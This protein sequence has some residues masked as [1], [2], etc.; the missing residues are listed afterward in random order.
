MYSDNGTEQRAAG[1]TDVSGGLP[2]ALELGGDLPC[3]RC[4][5]NLK[6]LSIRAVCPECGAPVRATLL[7]VVDPLASELQ[8]LSSPRLTAW[9]VLMWGVTPV[10]ACVACWVIRS[11]EVLSRS[12]ALLDRVEAWRVVVPLMAALSGLGSL[13]LIRPHARIPMASRMQAMFGVLSYVA[14]VPVIWAEFVVERPLP[15]G[16]ALT[17]PVGMWAVWGLV[18]CGLLILALV[19]LRPNARALAKR[20]LLMRSGQ[21][22]RQTMRSVAAVL[23]LCVVGYACGLLA[24][25]QIGAGADTARTVG[26]LV[27]AAGWLLFSIGMAGIAVDC[28]RLFAVIADQPLTMTDLLG[29]ARR[30]VP[31]RESRAWSRE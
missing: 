3:V 6:G 13:V 25:E 23:S 17:A 11:V 18:E 2:L 1:Q 4:R 28:W 8:P 29:S 9:G 10:V 20:S 12:T 15:T 5:Y 31:E 26:G 14:L 30:T 24:G 19:L 7:A 21:A 16:G 22:D 27:L